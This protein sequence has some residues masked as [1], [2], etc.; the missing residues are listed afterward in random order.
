M[1]SRVAPNTSCWNAVRFRFVDETRYVQQPG[2]CMGT[3]C[4]QQF[5]A[6][7]SPA[8]G[9][10]RVNERQKG[11]IG[12]EPLGAASAQQ[13]DT[14]LRQP[15]HRHVDEGRLADSRLPRHKRNLSLPGQHLLRDPVQHLERSFASDDA[16]RSRVGRHEGNCR[17]AAGQ[18]GQTGSCSCRIPFCRKRRARRSFRGRGLHDRSCEAIAA[19]RKRLDPGISAGDQRQHAP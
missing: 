7:R 3:D 10:Q 5:C 17:V 4:H 13:F 2:W 8:A 14:L 11:F 9:C 6:I 15:L 12:T 18:F 1:R 19:P 16:A